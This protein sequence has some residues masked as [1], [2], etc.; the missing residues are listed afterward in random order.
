MLGNFMDDVQIGG[1]LERQPVHYRVFMHH[2]MEMHSGEILEKSGM[3]EFFLPVEYVEIIGL[4]RL[5][6]GFFDL[7]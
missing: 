5:L 6:K 2:S 3:A 7:G 1:L 4:I